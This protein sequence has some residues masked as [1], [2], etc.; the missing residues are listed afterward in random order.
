M[1]T[2]SANIQNIIDKNDPNQKLIGMLAIMIEDKL[3][4]IENKIE[5][6]SEKV[7]AQK[8][9][10]DNHSLKCPLNIETRVTRLEEAID[11]VIFL[12]KNKWILALVSLGLLT[13]ST[14]GL[15]KI[16]TLII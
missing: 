10:S 4:G 13:L 2:L 6:V 1:A 12:R 11:F 5:I 8:I 7:N 9:I 3:D 16:I 14:Y 15:D